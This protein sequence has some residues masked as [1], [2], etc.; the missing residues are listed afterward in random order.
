MGGIEQAPVL[1][2]L[3]QVGPKGWIRDML[4]LELDSE[5]DASH[6]TSILKSAWASFK[7]RTPM[8]GTEAVPVG[9]DVKPTGMLK[10]Q[11]YREGEIVDFVVK[12]HRSDPGLPS[13]AQLKAQ[14][15]PNASMDTEKLCLR[16]RNGEWPTFGVD[17][18]P[19][20]MMQANLIKG[21]L[22]LNHLC[23]H[24]FADG[25]TM[26]KF[27]E[28]FAEDVRRAQGLS[29][30]QAAEIPITDRAKL[31]R[32]NKDRACANFAQE[33]LEFVHLPFTPE[34]LPDGLTKAQHHA[35]V[36]RFTPEA[37]RALKE[38]CA[39]RNVR[40]LK[41]K[42]PA[43]ELPEFVT[44]NDVLTALLWR[45]VQRAEQSDHSTIAADKHS[46]AQVALDA[47][48]RAHETIHPHTLGNILGYAAIA[49]PLSHV[50]SPD[51]ASLAD[52]AVSVRQA[53]AKCDKSYHDELAHYIENM[54]DVNRLAGIAFLD[55]PGANVLQSNWREF[56][57]YNIEWGPAFGH[58]LKAVR[59]PAHGV[60]SGFQIILPCPPDAPEGTVEMLVDL[61]DDAWSRMMT[62]EI[63]NRYAMNPTTTDYV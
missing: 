28:L 20:N 5:Y 61:S 43:A 21:G 39:P 23:F 47:R 56:D 32:S 22:L 35:H 9:P 44:T 49:L 60:C 40:L 30:H 62:D 42:I 57:Y 4:C 31:L 33:H 27:I 12:D 36:F 48:R 16:G 37:I 1:L 38:E 59:F 10:L 19:T 53:V 7:E 45:S 58:H 6:I 13:F 34:G 3:E 15:F 29:I 14:N 50:L 8:V 11:P 18:L 41:D 54:D 63:W 2:A 52:L 25:T 55:M 17:R 51:T 46:V 26:W 24:A